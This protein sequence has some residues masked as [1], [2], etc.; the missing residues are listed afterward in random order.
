MDLKNAKLTAFGSTRHSQS[1][2]EDD[3]NLKALLSAKTEIVTIFA[4]SSITQVKEILRISLD[5]NLKMI[6]DSVSYLK[7]RKKEVFYDAEHFFDG[8]K[9]NPKYALKTILAEQDAKAD[10]IIFCVTNGGTLP[11]EI[12]DIFFKLKSKSNSNFCLDEL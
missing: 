3:E 5:E 2:V 7:A 1:T 8:Y 4:K 12:T 11:R 9:R 6:A 10:C